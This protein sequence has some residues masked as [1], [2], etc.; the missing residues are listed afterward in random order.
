MEGVEHL[1]TI[2]K[3]DTPTLSLGGMLGGDQ[4]VL[5]LFAD[6][7]RAAKVI[8]SKLSEINNVAVE[9]VLARFCLS[10]CKVVHQLRIHG[11]TLAQ[12]PEHVSAYDDVVRGT[13]ERLFPGL[14]DEG[15]LQAGL[16]SS[17][18]GLG[19]RHAKKM[20]LLAF[21]ASRVSCR[22]KVQHLASAF[23]VA[24]LIN[25]RVFMENYDRTTEEVVSSFERSL[26]VDE[27]N[28]VRQVVDGA[29]IL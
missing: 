18:G 20:I 27:R 28:Q 11:E 26:D 6:K 12:H 17:V 5:D 25:P 13:L 14:E 4:A 21:I 16:G 1:A 15:Y 3:H 24:G 23:A 7:V 8:H 2:C 22:P 19:F 9:H 29:Q 10:S